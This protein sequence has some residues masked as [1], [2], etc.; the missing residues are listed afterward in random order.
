MHEKGNEMG[1]DFKIEDQGTIVLFTE[2]TEAAAEWVEANVEL[3]DWQLI[4]DRSFAADHRPAQQLI[5][6]IREAR[7]VVEVA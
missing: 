6:G 7:F 2:L 1:A 3:E 4:G 5:D